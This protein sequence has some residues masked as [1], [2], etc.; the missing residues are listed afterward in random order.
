MIKFL[1]FINQ[2]SKIS[3]KKIIS[4]SV[5][6]GIAN[7]L[8]LAIIN[9]AAENVFNDTITSRL[10]ILY[11]LAFLLYMYT[12]RFMLI[13]S[14]RAIEE[15]L[16]CVRVRIL[17]KL[18]QTELNFIEHS[19]RG[20]LYLRLTQDSNL[21]SQSI[22]LISSAGQAAILIMVC[23]VYILWISPLSFLLVVIF[24]IISVLVYLSHRKKTLQ[25]LNKAREKEG[26]FFTILNHLL[27][28]FKEIKLNQIKND[29]L[30]AH[31]Q[32]TSEELE[33]I[34]TEVGY[35]EVT[36]W[37][38][39]R[40]RLYSLLP[41]LVFVIPIFYSE[42]TND[43]YKITATVLFIMGPINVL[44]GSVPT[45]N[46][47]NL[48]LDNFKIL[49]NQIDVA[50]HQ[51]I[52]H[53]SQQLDDFHKLI[54]KNI[55]FCYLDKQKQTSFAVTIDNLIIEK[56]E[57]IFIV[58]GNGSGKSTLLKLLTG[59]YYPNTGSLHVDQQ[60]INNNNYVNFRELFSIIFTDFHLF[61]RLYGLKNIDKKKVDYW[62]IRMKLDDKTFYSDKGYFTNMELSTG[63]KKR[64][65][66]IAM[67]LEDKPVMIFDEFA[68]DQ[69]P[70][71]KK[72]FYET[73][74]PELKAQ[75]KTII[76]VTHDDQYFHCADKVFK[77]N[78]G[79][80]TLL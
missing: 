66:F 58:G 40:L 7:A 54:F 51:A 13:H 23:L 6:S 57:I 17:D 70:Y 38:A 79:Q 29:D 73:F 24:I 31:I 9:H 60:L 76:A 8:L 80:M 28:G 44:V 71:F 46:R 34:K 77:M 19:D 14:M 4:M 12:Q 61:N 69:D 47:V 53:S 18:R 56:G 65:A 49:E 22:V 74:L 33:Q 59:L 35:L 45:L 63:Q 48:A 11:I 67:L 52:N 1:N 68:A 55:N 26:T 10:F 64:L 42:H 30:F 36:D 2:E 41:I 20:D 75:Q 3:I 25:Q 50:T 5:I 43:I 27:D 21:I 39:A 62:L 72:L 15:A 16:R 32:Q 37:M 78:Q